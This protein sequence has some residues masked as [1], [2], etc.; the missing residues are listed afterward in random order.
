MGGPSQLYL[1]RELE[2]LTL[3]AVSM[4][5]DQK[6]TTSSESGDRH[7]CIFRMPDNFRFVI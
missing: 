7:H 2:I 3:P 6:R 4:Q 5:V 1:C